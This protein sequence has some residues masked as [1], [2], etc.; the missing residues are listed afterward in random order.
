MFQITQESGEFIVTFPFGYHFGFNHGYNCSESN[1]FATTRWIEY[2]KRASHCACYDDEVTIDKESFVERF[3]PEKYD[4][5]MAGN[6][7]GVHP[8]DDTRRRWPCGKNKQAATNIS[9]DEQIS[10]NA[11]SSNVYEEHNYCS[12]E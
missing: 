3:Q 4:A 8:E 9:Q 2:G 1:N 12:L 7:W 5:W 11:S 10:L 6:D